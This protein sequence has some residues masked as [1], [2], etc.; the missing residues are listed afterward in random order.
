MLRN[1]LF[2]SLTL[3]EEVPYPALRSSPT[4]PLLSQHVTAQPSP[5]VE[6]EAPSQPAHKEQDEESLATVQNEPQHPQTDIIPELPI[7]DD[8]M[9]NIEEKTEVV[10]ISKDKEKEPASHVENKEAEAT[11]SAADMGNESNVNDCS[12]TLNFFQ[13]MH[14]PLY[15]F[16]QITRITPLAKSPLRTSQPPYPDTLNRN[17]DLYRYTTAIN[18]LID[19]TINLLASICTLG[20]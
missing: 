9:D 6:L 7:K 2:P 14:S 19:V 10:V 8:K 5:S 16:R 11:P 18:S 15:R 13:L 3:A 20:N 17:I 4:S 12:K 1:G